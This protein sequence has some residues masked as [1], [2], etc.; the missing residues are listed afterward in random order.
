[1][2]DEMYA[3]SRR[4]PVVLR[5]Y[6]DGVY[7]VTEQGALALRDAPLLQHRVAA[8]CHRFLC[9]GLDAIEGRPGAD[10]LVGES[11]GTVAVVTCRGRA[12]LDDHP[13][14]LSEILAECVRAVPYAHPADAWEVD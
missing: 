4:G 14:L 12:L 2:E 5:G 7:A 8:L 3:D 13:V 10:V 1:V 11:N 9:S 6:E